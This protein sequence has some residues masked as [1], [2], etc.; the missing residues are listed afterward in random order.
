M[1]SLQQRITFFTDLRLDTLASAA[2]NLKSQLSEL[3]K[4]REQ[5]RKSQ[6]SA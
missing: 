1:S 6:S 4:L 5:V 2:A 3:E